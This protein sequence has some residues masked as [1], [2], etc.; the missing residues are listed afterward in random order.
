MIDTSVHPIADEFYRRCPDEAI[1]ATETMHVDGRVLLPGMTLESLLT[2]MAALAGGGGALVVQ[3]G[4]LEG[5]SMH[6]VPG[7]QPVE[8]ARGR[9]P[10]RYVHAN[11]QA[12]GILADAPGSDALMPIP[13]ADAATRLHLSAAQVAS[14][15]ALMRQVQRL[16]LAHVGLRACNTGQDPDRLEAIR[17]FFGAQRLSAPNLRDSYG[18]GDVGSPTTSADAWARWRRAHRRR[19]EYADGALGGTLAVTPRELGDHRVSIGMM[20]ESW[21]VAERWVGAHLPAGAWQ[22][23]GSTFI[24]HALWGLPPIFSGEPAYRTHIITV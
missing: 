23:Q 17:R 19:H 1:G 16:R 11:A 13:D 22:G 15:R 9:Q 3:H 14:L 12:M 7:A 24:W 20:A 2:S 18:L 4:T 5:L 10:A 8:P 21:T 6:L